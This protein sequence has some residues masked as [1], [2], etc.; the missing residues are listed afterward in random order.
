RKTT[1]NNDRVNL[2]GW[3][4]EDHTLNE[5]QQVIARE[6]IPEFRPENTAYNDL[7]SIPT[8]DQ[9][10]ELAEANYKKNGKIIGLYIE[11]KQPTYFK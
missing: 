10:N 1:K 3:I 6:R 8:L 11:T 9:V 5:L 7:Y 4:T 2:T